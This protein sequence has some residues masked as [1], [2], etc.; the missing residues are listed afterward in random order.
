MSVARPLMRVPAVQALL[1]QLAALLLAV[2][3]RQGLSFAA[4][5]LPALGW[6]F[7]QGCA[8]AAFSWRAGLARWWLPIQLMFPVAVLLVDA[9]N[10]P[11]LVFLVGFVF[12]LLLFWSTFRTQV[13]FYP[14]TAATW[15]AVEA[16]LPRGPVHLI[17]IGSGFGGFVLSLA[18][19]HPQGIFSG[20]EIAPLPWLVSRIRALTNV[21]R[22]NFVLGDY[23]QL[24]FSRY[25][26]VFAYLS[27]VAMDSLWEKARAEMRPG[28]LLLSYEF[29]I[30]GVTP[31]VTINTSNRGGILYGWRI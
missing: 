17:D 8:A 6:A 30:E 13:P 2:L 7:L 31:A 10:L 16:L 3:L 4:L 19:R 29:T 14:S 15:R 18:G 5:P 28:S 23:M 9:L 1:L 26:V 21:G 11:P 20:I 22:A 27:P 25:D 24:D 12:F